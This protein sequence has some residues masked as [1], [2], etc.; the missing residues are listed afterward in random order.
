MYQTDAKGN[1][2]LRDPWVIRL[3][4]KKIT[5]TLK[6]IY[7]YKNATKKFSNLSTLTGI[8]LTITQGQVKF[9]RTWPH[10]ISTKKKKIALRLHERRFGLPIGWI[11]L[12]LTIWLNCCKEK[13]CYLTKK[14]TE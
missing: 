10:Q 7:K 6:K 13:C 2:I 5:S 14:I 11:G 8:G 9:G 3:G 4:L 1:A 12:G